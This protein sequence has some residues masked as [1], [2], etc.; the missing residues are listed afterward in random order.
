[1]VRDAGNWNT[2]INRGLLLAPSVNYLHKYPLESVYVETL[3][4]VRKHI[5]SFYRPSDFLTYFKFQYSKVIHVTF[6]FIDMVLKFQVPTCKCFPRIFPCTWGM[7]GLLPS[8][9]SIFLDYFTNSKSFKEDL[10]KNRGRA[11]PMFLHMASR[12]ANEGPLYCFIIDQN[13]STL[14]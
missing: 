8:F 13:K 6:S 2:L 10:E 11:K 4:H 9:F 3:G 7:L 5:V 14:S 12:R 1:M